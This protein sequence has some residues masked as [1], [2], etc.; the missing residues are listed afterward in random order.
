LQ[1]G[2]CLSPLPPLVFAGVVS[3]SPHLPA[4]RII[5]GAACHA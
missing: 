3:S 1:A 2:R 5:P 4:N